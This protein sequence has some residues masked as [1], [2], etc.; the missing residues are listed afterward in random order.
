MRLSDFIF[1]E[2]GAVTVDWVV[3]TGATVG[4]GLAT[5]GVV[6]GGIENLSGDVDASLRQTEIADAFP[7][8]EPGVLAS[9]DFSGGQADGWIGGVA[10]DVGG[11]LGE[12]YQIAANQLAQLNL[13]VPAGA[14]QAVLSFDLIGMDSLDSE[15]ATISINGTP[16]SIATGNFGSISFADQGAPGV[17]VALEEGARRQELGGNTN[18]GWTESVTTVTITVDDPG[19]DVT[20]GV[21]SGANQSVWDE[22]YA[23]DNVSVEAR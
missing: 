9:F 12:V 8:F 15:A 22:S 10:T 5:M 14:S 3:L 4:L 16:V 20:L 11:E 13:E 7:G 1:S 2:T 6:S 23:L 17:S 18:S 19:G 21:H